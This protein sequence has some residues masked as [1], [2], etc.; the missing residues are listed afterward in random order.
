MGRF[1]DSRGSRSFFVT[2]KGTW[3]LSYAAY[4]RT[5]KRVAKDCGFNPNRFGTHSIRIGGA[6]ILAAGHPNH[7]IRMMGRWN[8]ETFMRYLRSALATMEAALASLVNPR[9]FTNED[10][11][12]LSSGVSIVTLIN[13][14]TTGKI[15]P[16]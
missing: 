9:F 16:P 11:L 2:H 1:S 6:S 10:L 8:S 14:S 15:I 12:K 13:L 5:V 4:L 3:Q 7:Y